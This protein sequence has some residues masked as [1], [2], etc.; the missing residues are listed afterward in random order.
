MTVLYGFGRV[1]PYEFDQLAVAC[2]AGVT[3]HR[4]YCPLLVV[5]AAVCAGIVIDREAGITMGIW[6]AVAA[7]GL[8]GWWLLWRRSFDRAAAVTLAVSLA[9]IGGAWHHQR[10]HYFSAD[11]IGLFAREKAE[12]VCLEA[13]AVTGPRLVPAPAYDPL[14]SL[15]PADQTRMA[16]RLLGIRDGGRWLSA[17]GGAQLSMIGKPTNI[18]AG[19]RLRILGH[20]SALGRPAIPA[21]PTTPSWP[22]VEVK[23]RRCM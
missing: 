18:H 15:R 10:W 22:A 1:T 21:K 14:R 8:I 20:L 16:I 11:E 6:L 5:L 3:M 2:G 13:V 7:G 17:S 9:A 12:P 19:D 4:Q 23:W